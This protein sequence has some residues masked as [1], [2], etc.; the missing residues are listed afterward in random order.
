LTENSFSQVDI[1]VVLPAYR[2]GYV[3][4]DA[5]SA[6][7]E[8]LVHTGL[9]HRLIVVVDGDVDG[10]ANRLRAAA[11]PNCTVL[12]KV[13][14]TG[15][16]DSLKY[17]ISRTSAP[18][19][20]L[21]DADLDVDPVFL[22]HGIRV[23]QERPDLAGVIGS[24]RHQDTEINYPLTRRVLSSLYF[25]LAKIFVGV[26][27][28]DTQTGAK[29]F[30]GKVLRHHAA[31]ARTNG[32]AFE[33]EL[34]SRLESGGLEIA[35]LPIRIT[36]DLFGSTMSLKVGLEALKDLARVRRSLQSRNRKE[37]RPRPIERAR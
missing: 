17:G 22:N 8:R 34:L 13:A 25:Y 18:L 3:I 1:D 15:K 6:V 19:V 27:V 31:E 7:R 33:L 24:K 14:N 5:L 29:I 16:G 21:F 10:T 23:M 12:V 32:V 28:S 4:L 35:E 2:K 26:N 11:L 30:R 9:S 36:H 20:A 37:R